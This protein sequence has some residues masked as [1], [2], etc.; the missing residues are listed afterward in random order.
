MNM[1]LLEGQEPLTC[2]NI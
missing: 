2:V 1:K